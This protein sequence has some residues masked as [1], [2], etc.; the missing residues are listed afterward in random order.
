MRFTTPNFLAGAARRFCLLSSLTA[1]ATL[2]ACGGGGGSDDKGATPSSVG[3]ADAYVGT[4]VSDCTDLGNGT[5]VKARAVATKL[6]AN[7]I[8]VQFSGAVF[9]NTTCA[10][11]A[12]FVDTGSEVD[13]FAGTK[14]TTSGKK[15]DK[16][17]G[18]DDTDE[19]KGIA[20]I[21]GGVLYTEDDEAGVDSEGY[22]NNLDL[23][24]PFRK[25]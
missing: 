9:T 24:H 6:D 15:V 12:S 23:I 17:V 19:Y 25:Q 2:T 20:L 7:R 4:W 11:T 16:F 10:G 22:P 1:L 18:K 5:H 3:T 8:Q 14:T 13:T 21:E